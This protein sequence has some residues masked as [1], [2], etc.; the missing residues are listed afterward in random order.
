MSLL[1]RQKPTSFELG[2]NL[3]LGYISKTQIFHDKYL[4]FSHGLTFNIMPTMEQK[5]GGG[6]AEPPFW[7]I[8]PWGSD[9][10]ARP[11]NWDC[12][13][14]FLRRFSIGGP[15]PSGICIRS[16]VTS[17]E[18]PGTTKARALRF[19]KTP[20]SLVKDPRKAQRFKASVDLDQ[21]WKANRSSRPKGNARNRPRVPLSEAKVS[22]ITGSI[23]E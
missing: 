13:E 17:A 9:L 16:G 18:K 21:L 23:P 5:Q 3:F 15:N 10:T 1:S 12:F 6:L 4:L 11:S 14:G 19:I 8:S 22:H 2:T 20:P 7:L